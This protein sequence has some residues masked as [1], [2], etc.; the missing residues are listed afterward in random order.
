G[1]TFPSTV[2][3][4]VHR[5]TIYRFIKEHLIDAVEHDD[6]LYAV[7]RAF[8]ESQRLITMEDNWNLGAGH[9]I[10]TGIKNDDTLRHSLESVQTR[11]IEIQ[12]QLG[13][14]TQIAW[15]ISRKN[16]AKDYKTKRK[17]CPTFWSLLDDYLR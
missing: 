10:L 6:D 13:K 17:C 12:T 16:S 8:D 1:Y 14:V 2:N 4:V 3:Y 5:E 7:F 11:R 9:R 15:L